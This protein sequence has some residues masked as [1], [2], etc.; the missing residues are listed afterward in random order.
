MGHLLLRN[1]F[2]GL[3]LVL[4]SKGKLEGAAQVM[5]WRILTRCVFVFDFY[6]P[7]CL[8]RR[9]LMMTK[10]EEGEEEE[11]EVLPAGEVVCTRARSAR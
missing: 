9:I 5:R 11:E 1:A 8:W 4:L 6:F 7:K 10:K 3:I 2:A